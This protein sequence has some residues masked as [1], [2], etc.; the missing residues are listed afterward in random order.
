MQITANGIQIEYE[1]FGPANGVPFVLI[2]GLGTQMTHWPRELFGGF[3]EFGYRTIIF[4]NR[5]IG[6]SQRC[7][8]EGISGDAGDILA[9][10]ERGQSLKSAYTL[11]DMALDVIGL[12]DALEIKKAHIFGISMGGGI[13]QLLAANHADRLLSGT[14][15]MTAAHFQGLGHLNRVL[16]YPETREQHQETWVQGNHEWGSPGFAVSDGYLREEAG[17]AWDRGYDAAGINRQALAAVSSGDR[18]EI[19]K[20]V[21]LPCLVI[22]GAQDTLVPP[23]AGKEIAS[24]IPDAQFELI[25]GMGHTITPRLSPVITNLVHRFIDEH[26]PNLEPAKDPA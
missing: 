16:V 13:T 11:D 14:I 25:E 8:G 17:I 2:R 24:L 26:R 23:E 6:L 12:M 20:T 3:A 18:R 21:A 7:P 19:L 5:D 10:V 15:V 9:M 1:E 4:D 22:H